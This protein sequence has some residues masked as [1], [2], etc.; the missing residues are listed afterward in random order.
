MGG[1]GLVHDLF[2]R[3]AAARL[4]EH[5][6]A[7][8]SATGDLGGSFGGI[9]DQVGATRSFRNSRGGFTDGNHDHSSLGGEPADIP[10]ADYAGVVEA[11]AADRLDMA[12]LGGFT[13]VQARLKTGNA[14]PLVQREQDQQFTSKFITADPQV[15][16]LQ[17]LKAIARHNPAGLSQKALGRLQTAL[18]RGQWRA[19]YRPTAAGA[20]GGGHDVAPGWEL[21]WSA[22]ARRALVQGQHVCRANLAVATP[23]ILEEYAATG[24]TK[25]DI[26][27][28]ASWVDIPISTPTDRKDQRS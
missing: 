11:L 2:H 15:K 3:S 16:S 24:I 4:E 12:W 26:G 7:R 14:I 18:R 25:T 9:R 22:P 10:V 6:I 21:Q 19:Q 17:D 20:G 8:L 27:T 13:F 5:G 23:L 1:E 28:V